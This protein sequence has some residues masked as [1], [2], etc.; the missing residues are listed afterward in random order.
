MRNLMMLSQVGA[1][2]A[3][4]A[5]PAAALS[6]PPPGD[7]I[8]GDTN[9]SAY[10][11]S[12][13]GTTVVGSSSALLDFEAFRWTQTLGMVSLGDLATG[14][15][16]SSA[17]AVSGNGSVAAGYGTTGTGIE[18]AS[19]TSPLFL[20]TGL[21][22]LSGANPTSQANGISANGTV[23]VGQTTTTAGNEAFMWTSGGGMVSLGDFPTGG[24]NSTA[25]AISDDGSVIVGAGLHAG[26][27]GE[28]FR[29]RANVMV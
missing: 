6:F 8:G 27:I 18:A 4:A 15:S 3:L 23:I 20:P 28:A 29:W 26:P 13:D 10:A 21:G 16:E 17:Y 19:W 22:T 11:I 14:G 24:T 7:L 2:A 9:S 5:S 25:T 1:I 12:N